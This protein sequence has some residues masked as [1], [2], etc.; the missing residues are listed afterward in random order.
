MRF[1]FAQY[2]G[3]KERAG[4]PLACF[5]TYMFAKVSGTSV[6]QMPPD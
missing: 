2:I 6:E 4:N 5:L 1:F 3:K